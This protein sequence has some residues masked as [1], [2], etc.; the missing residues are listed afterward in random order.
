MKLVLTGY[1]GSGKTSVGKHLSM[2]LGLTLKDLDHEIELIENRPVHQIFS[3]KGEIYFRKKEAE[4]LQT[5]LDSDEKLIL[6]T[7]GGT[8]CYG[9]NMKDLLEHKN[10]I[11]FYLNTPLDTLVRRL[12][13]EKVK[14][15]L[16]E[17]LKS[18]EDLKEFI[19]KH[20]F[21]RIPFYSQAHKIIHTD[22]LSVSEITEHIIAQL[23]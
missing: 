18:E 10:V 14:R 5:I 9:S 21:E 15:P 17:H 16:I 23:F 19:G 13:N 8:P 12:S 11:T 20:L 6:S 1:M 22:K 7:G 4:V 3:E 2:T